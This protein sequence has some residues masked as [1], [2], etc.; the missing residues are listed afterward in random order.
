MQLLTINNR[1]QMYAKFSSNQAVLPSF[2][3]LP[4]VGYRVFIWLSLV[5]GT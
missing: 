4:R 3:R 1:K 5:S 2:T